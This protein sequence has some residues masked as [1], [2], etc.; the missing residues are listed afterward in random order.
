MKVEWK[1]GL[2]KRR[3]L[4]LLVNGYFINFAEEKV[5]RYITNLRF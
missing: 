3:L 2:R 1:P 4:L 5:G